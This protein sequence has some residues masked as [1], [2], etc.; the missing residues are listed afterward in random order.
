VTY[1]IELTRR[2]LLSLVTRV[3]YADGV[4][5]GSDFVAVRII[6]FTF[7]PA[8]LRINIG[9][10]VLWTNGDDSPHRIDH[11]ATPRFFRSQVLFPRDQYGH[12]FNVA[13]EFRYRCAIHP[14]MRGTIQVG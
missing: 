2:G 3:A 14:H 1:V 9:Q 5:D 6:D 7:Q 13:G 11:D 10:S 8:I 4:R 12:Q